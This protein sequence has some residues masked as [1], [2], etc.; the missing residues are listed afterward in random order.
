MA[1]EERPEE[2]EET[3]A[4]STEEKSQGS[5]TVLILVV[6]IV[7]L[8]ACGAL[9]WILFFRG[10]DET[11]EVAPTLAPTAEEVAPP[12]TEEVEATEIPPIPPTNT[13]VPSEDAVW[14]SIV[15]EGKMVVG[16]SADYPPFEYYTRNFLLDGFDVAL[17]GEIGEVLDLEVEIRDMAFDG[18]LGSLSLNNTDVVISALSITP[19]R[20]GIIA[21]TNIYFVSEDAV[22]ANAESDIDAIPSEGELAFLRV[23]VQS[24]TVYDEWLTA[25]LVETGRMPEENLHRYQ[26]AG[27]AVEDLADG[28][29]ELVVLDLEP[30]NVAVERG[31]VKIVA[32]GLN[33]QRYAMAVPRGAP[34]LQTELNRALLQLQVSGRVGELVEEYIGIP[35]EELPP[36]PT[37]LPPQPTP[38]PGPEPECIDEMSSVQD[39]SYDDQDMTNPPQLS[40]GQPFQKGWRVRNTGT[41]TWDRSY[42]LVP[43]G[44]NV[45][46]ARMG[47]AP[48]LVQGL[49]E[50]GQTYDFW[51]DLVAP[52]SPGVYQEFWTMRNT[53]TGILFGDRVWVMVEVISNP[54][55]TP[56]PTQT[57]SPQIVFFADP[58]QI[59]QGD[60]ST[61]N[62]HTE[63]VSAV[64]LYP[65][66]QPWQNNGVQG[67]GQRMVC[68]SQTT[69]YE[70]RVVKT[71]GT[72]EIRNATVHVTP[73]NN[74]PV[75]S[76]FTAE[77]NQINPGDCVLLTWRV[78]GANDTVLYRENVVIWPGAPTNGSVQDCPPNT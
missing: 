11:A 73:V 44:G 15:E 38:P 59:N 54:T 2:F 10:D 32:Q 36:I 63:N 35:E 9:A 39:L 61:L 50:P 72:V 27:K 68:P 64:Y 49:V 66:G 69:T 47:G 4:P 43:V 26:Q 34:Q 23:G 13:T 74:A 40:P 57:P 33:P 48:V 22:L 75:I 60:C 14:E 51:A 71:N 77:P 3:P 20:Q 45:P 53:S 19:E 24:G 8:I 18:L 56:V 42:A 12:A 41:C 17:I 30:A 76:R 7:A 6:A 31:G 5:N 29:I 25:N 37:P 70:L 78:E 62:W 46:A 65:Q 1:G 21:F 52:L 58:E 16:L 67:I 28:L 55:P